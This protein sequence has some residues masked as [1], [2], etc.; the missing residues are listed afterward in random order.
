MNPC[1][2]AS[3]PIRPLVGVLCCNEFLDRPVQSVATR[4]V[5]PLVGISGVDVVLVP[6]LPDVVDIVSLSRRLDGLLLTGSRSNV[7]PSAYGR[8]QIGAPN[9]DL[10]RDRMAFAL[11]TELIEAAK[12]VFG[13]CR[14]FQELNVLF[15]GSLRPDVAGLHRHPEG[16][17]VAFDRLFSH[18]HSVEVLPGGY[19]A[20]GESS[21]RVIEVNSV[22]EQGIDQLGRGLR[23]EAVAQDD[24]L[25]EAI[26]T[27]VGGAPVLAVQWHPEWESG[28][29]RTSHAFFEQ[30][31][32]AAA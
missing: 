3:G 8:N 23:V 2:R 18:R 27:T 11:A 1:A 10:K 32:A 22:H 16:D 29:C 25:I 13:I 7:S 6:A 20:C 14:G 31:G 21:P 4:F 30:L 15:G 12:P 28:S 17:E 19:L 26:S 24:G 5:D 9:L